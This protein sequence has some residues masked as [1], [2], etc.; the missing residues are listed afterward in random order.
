MSDLNRPDLLGVPEDVVAYIEALEAR[1]A[2]AAATR[3]PRAE[4]PFE[5]DEEPT[6]INVISIT[7]AGV[8]KRTPR[9]LYP[10]QRRAGMGIFDI[11]SPEEEPPVF[12]LTADESAMLILLTNQGRAF[13]L[14]VQEIVET[15]VRGRG[16]PILDNL[17]LRAG[18]VVNIITPDRGSGFFCF[19]TERGQVRRMAAQVVGRNMVSGTLLHDPKDGGA[20]VG[21]CWSSGTDELMII[22]REG[23][24]IRFAERLVPVRGTLG[25]RIE[26]GEHI[27]SVAAAPADGGV[28]LLAEDGKGTVRML[29]G[30]AANK[31]PG[32]GGKTLIKADTLVAAF[33][34][35]PDNDD[36]FLIS[37]LGKIIRFSAA[38]IPAKEGVVQGV[39]CMTLRADACTAAA[40]SVRP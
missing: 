40:S 21:A 36:L 20:P 7:R 39:I 9:H 23:R 8:A 5:P 12:L 27:F 11:D 37:R 24:A 19:V 26:N 38:E 13:R 18:E 25:M 14:P 29:E 22:A 35:H 33:A 10:R 28:F 30:F 17:P 1:L 32:S 6:T 2:G 3:T 16:Q 34:V 31:A 4:V 15:P